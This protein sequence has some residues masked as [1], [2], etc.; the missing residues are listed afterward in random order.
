MVEEKD[1]LRFLSGMPKTQKDFA[2]DTIII[3]VPGS[4]IINDYAIKAF[5][6]LLINNIKYYNGDIG[7]M[8]NNGELLTEAQ[9]GKSQ[10]MRKFCEFE[11]GQLRKRYKNI[12]KR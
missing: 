7:G 10:G 9:I 8:T 4:P 1:Q 5:E 3:I 11:L 2:S 6:S 12:L